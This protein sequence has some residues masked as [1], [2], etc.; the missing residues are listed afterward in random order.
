M[1]RSFAVADVCTLAKVFGVDIRSSRNQHERS[2]N[3]AARS[4][5]AGKIQRR[6]GANTR[7]S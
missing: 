2:V 4:R 5:S 6:V 3:R 7:V 1:Q